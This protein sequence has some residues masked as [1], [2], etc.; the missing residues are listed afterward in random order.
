LS[1]SAMQSSQTGSGE[2][3]A[4]KARTSSRTDN[5]KTPARPRP[6]PPIA[7]LSREQHRNKML[8]ERE[9]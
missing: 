3:L 1:L 6:R 9:G 2:S 5:G 4:T 8:C 7:C